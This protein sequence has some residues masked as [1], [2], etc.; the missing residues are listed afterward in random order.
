MDN[1]PMNGTGFNANMQRTHPNTTTTQQGNQNGC[2][3]QFS[4]VGNIATLDGSKDAIINSNIQMTPSSVNNFCNRYK[5]YTQFRI[6]SSNA[7]NTC[8]THHS[9]NGQKKR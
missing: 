2:R 3:P 8:S 7:T 5:H 9:K 1:S 4:S 6:V